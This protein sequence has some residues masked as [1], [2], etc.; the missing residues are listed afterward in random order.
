MKNPLI[1]IAVIIAGAIIAGAIIFTNQA[2]PKIVDQAGVKATDVELREVDKDDHILGNPNA[3]VTIVEYSDFQCPFCQTFHT[4]MNQIMDEYGR[5]GKVAWVYRHHPLDD[6]YGAPSNLHPEARP[7]AIAS[8]CVARE[9]DNDAF[10][11]YSNTLFDNQ[12]ELG[13]D[14]YIQ[15][16][17]ALGIDRESFTECLNDEKILDLVIEDEQNGELRFGTPYSVA[18]TS[19]GRNAVPINGALPYTAVK[20]IIDGL[21][22]E[23]N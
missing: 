9:K 23:T 21:L 22:A 17:V 2:S 18:I 5:D 20:E 8:E 13:L 16:A 11:S 19:D 7:A 12:A 4:T 6:F 14:L 10:W 1:P 15:E 3:E